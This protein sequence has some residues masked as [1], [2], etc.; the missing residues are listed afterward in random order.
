MRPLPQPQTLREAVRAV[1]KSSV[2]DAC[3]PKRFI[4][5]TGKGDVPDL[6]STC[7]GLITSGETLKW[8]EMAVIVFPE[9]LTLEDLVARFGGMWGF[10]QETIEIAEARARRFDQL[11]GA[12]RYG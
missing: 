4:Q 11:A 1:I 12:Q 7:E 9:L 10:K 2:A 3:Y 6:L 5:V 8:L